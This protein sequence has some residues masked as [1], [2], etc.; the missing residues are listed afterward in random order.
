[1]QGYYMPQSSQIHTRFILPQQHP[2]K[3]SRMKNKQ[4]SWNQES[5]H[6]NFHNL[7]AFWSSHLSYSS[8]IYFLWENMFIFIREIIFWIEFSL[9]PAFSQF[10]VTPVRQVSLWF[11]RKA[12]TIWVFPLNS[13]FSS[14]RAKSAVKTEVLIEIHSDEYWLSKIEIQH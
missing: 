2:P 6:V 5:K 1:M 11:D 12:T 9:L 3:A 7:I 4:K 10:W 13:T 14:E 8:I